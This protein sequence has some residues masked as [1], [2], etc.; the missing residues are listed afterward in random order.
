MQHYMTRDLIVPRRN[1]Y[2][3]GILLA[4]VDRFVAEGADVFNIRC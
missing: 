3:H 4:W 2:A 1:L